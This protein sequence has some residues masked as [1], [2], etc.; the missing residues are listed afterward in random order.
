M[1]ERPD[2]GEGERESLRID[3]EDPILAGVPGA[4]AGNDVP[5]PRTHSPRRKGEAPAL[6]AFEKS[7]V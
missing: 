7:R 4:L 1:D 6:F 2:I 5:I 3:A